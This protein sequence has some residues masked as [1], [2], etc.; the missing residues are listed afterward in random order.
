MERMKSVAVNEAHQFDVV[1]KE[2]PIPKS[3][4]VRIKVMACGVCHSDIYTK[5]G[6]WPNIQYP[7]IPGHEVAGIIDEIGPTISSSTSKWK[8]G[9]AVGVGWA[10][11]LC[12]QCTP[13]RRGEFV[14]CENHQVTGIHYDGGYAQYMIAP[15]EALAAIPEGL[16]FEEAAPLLCAG[17][18]TFNAL[19]NSGARPGDRVAILGIGGLGHLAVQFANKMG[20]ETVAISRGEDKKSLAKKLGAHVYLDTEKDAVAELN[21][22]GGARVILATAPSGKAITPFVEA[23]GLRGELV[24][25]G[26]STDP[27]EISARQLIPLKRTIRGWASGSSIDSEEAMKFCVLTGVRALI[28]KFPLEKAADAYQQMISNK[29]KFRAVLVF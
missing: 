2:V 15:V 6:L 17:V 5:E 16:S 22:M 8:K 25:V 24:I 14:C 13:C 19:R 7:R 21:K 23:L 1:Q 26:A 3:G 10:G 20:F 28:E 4:E 11:R 12:G 18:T 27:I 29:A 9:Q